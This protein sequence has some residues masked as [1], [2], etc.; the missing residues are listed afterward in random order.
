MYKYLDFIDIAVPISYFERYLRYLY[1]L[2]L[3][4]S[5]IFY[6]YRFKKKFF[7]SISLLISMVLLNI[8]PIR[9]IYEN[10]V[11]FVNVGQGDCIVIK[12]KNHA[13]MIDTGGNAKFSS[14]GLCF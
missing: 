9:N 2:I 8:V 4:L 3:F 7:I 1:Y 11:Y 5:F 10:A 6:E 12:N 14:R 13:V